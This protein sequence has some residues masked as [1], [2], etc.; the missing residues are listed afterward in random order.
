MRR[1]RWFFVV[2]L[3]AC[4]SSGIGNGSL[5]FAGTNGS[6]GS[7]GAMGGSGGCHADGDCP[8]PNTFAGPAAE[9]DLP[10]RRRLGIEHVLPLR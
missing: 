7:G 9:E 6:G 5:S 10:L 4:T 1:A 2:A 8:Q 3:A